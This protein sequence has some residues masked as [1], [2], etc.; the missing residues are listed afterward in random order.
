MK[1]IDNETYQKIEGILYNCLTTNDLNVKK[2]IESLNN[3]F[4]ET[5]HLY[6]LQNYYYRRN[7]YTNRYPRNSLLFKKICKDL[8]I[9][10]PTLYIIKKEVIYKA[11]MIFYKNG[12]I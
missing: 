4:K 5:D 11:A 2:S 12:V 10:E 3:F 7:L 6:F 8:Y 9:E 1:L